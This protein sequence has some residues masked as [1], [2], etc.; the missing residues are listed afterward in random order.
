[1]APN[2]YYLGH[3]GVVNFGGLR[4]GGLSGIFMEHNYS[5]VSA[6]ACTCP[7]WTRCEGGLR[8]GGLSGSFM[9][10]KYIRASGCACTGTVW[11]RCKV[12][13]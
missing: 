6:H 7:V 13:P 11:G 10:H 5:R 4:I 1:M 3:A 8:I 2:I 9:E 12:S